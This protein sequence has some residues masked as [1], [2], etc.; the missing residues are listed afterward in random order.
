MV[1]NSDKVD[2]LIV[3]RYFCDLV[4]SDLAELP[5]LGHE[6]YSREFHL[7]PG[8]AYNAAAALHRLGVSSAWPCRFGN[9]PFSQFV[10]ASA[11]REGMNPA[12]FTDLD[13]PSL[14]LT[15]AFSFDEERAF[16]SY[17]DPLPPY[18]F[19]NLIMELR[20]RWIYITH[21]VLGDELQEMVVAA[22]RTGAKIF[23]DC[24]AHAHT[25]E[26]LPVQAALRTV[27]VFSPNRAEAERLTGLT[28][29]TLM[30]QAL[31]AY[32][33]MVV[34]KDG[35]GGSHLQNAQSR[36]HAAALEVKVTDTTGAGDNFDSGFLYGLL[37]AYSLQ[38]C[39]VAG[40]ICGGLS[41]RGFGGTS[42]SA[43]EEELHRYLH[44]MAKFA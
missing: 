7:I 44:Q 1:E 2:V 13:H 27:D 5:R 30:L 23:M 42:T 43:T 39:L 31:A 32:A 12:I 6:V 37:H 21:L 40:N 33:P 4:F 29:M 9:D 18:A 19:G 17:S 10:K 36:L 22:G 34:I 14:H 20:P 41:A 3:G 15:A 8:G 38:A 24:Q 28:E 35:K 26:E 25:L 16:L 11:L